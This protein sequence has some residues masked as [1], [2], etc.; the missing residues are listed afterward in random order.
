MGNKIYVAL[1][2]HP[3]LNKQ[4]D[5]VTTSITNMDIH[6]IARTCLTF[7]VQ[8]YYIV[9]PLE[10]QRQLYNKLISFWQSEI[11]QNYQEDRAKALSIVRFR[12][13]LQDV[14]KDIKNQEK[15]DPVNIT[16]TAKV[17]DGQI[18]YENL[19]SDLSEGDRPVLLLFGTGYGL[20]EEIHQS[21]DYTLEPLFGVGEYNHLSVRCAVALI[22]DRLVPKNKGGKHGFVRGSQQA[23]S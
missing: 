11:G 6:D 17:R 5:I 23:A 13:T 2:H 12:S 18:S 15:Y 7:G 8:N 16:T 20:S 19:Q 14:I 3:V 10:S 22:L 21:A 1:L 4:G 9:N